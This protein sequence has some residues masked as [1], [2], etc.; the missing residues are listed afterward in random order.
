VEPASEHS[1]SASIKHDSLELGAVERAQRVGGGLAERR[2]AVEQ[3]Q[4]VG[5]DQA[6]QFGAVEQAQRVGGGQA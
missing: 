1:A 4:H 5:G 6:R 2:E 3:A